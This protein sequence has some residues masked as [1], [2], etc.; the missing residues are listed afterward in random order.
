MLPL[1]LC[2]T[3]Q[4]FI[5]SLFSF[6]TF[7]ACLWQLTLIANS[8]WYSLYASC[9]LRQDIRSLF[10]W[11]GQS[12]SPATCCARVFGLPLRGTAQVHVAVPLCEI[13]RW[14]KHVN[15]NIWTAVNSKFWNWEYIRT[16]AYCYHCG[17]QIGSDGEEGE[18]V[19]WFQ[20]FL[21]FC[22]FYSLFCVI[23]Q[24]LNCIC[25][26]LRTLCL[27]NLRQQFKQEEGTDRVFWN[28]GK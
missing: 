17:V 21:I 4:L 14:N 25:W 18:Y 22:I 12:S 8:A 5:L 11:A 28:V 24:R 15:R 19:S 1:L 9:F 23:S 2:S 16:I 6:I 13:E 3:W 7:S 27:L 10:G 26:R 20:T